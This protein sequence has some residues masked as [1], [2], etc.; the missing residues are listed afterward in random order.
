MQSID[1]CRTFTVAV[2]NKHRGI[3]ALYKSL[4]A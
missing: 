3:T 2:D 1:K 4:H